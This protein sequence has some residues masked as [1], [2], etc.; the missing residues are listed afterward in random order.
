LV[1]L[2]KG[3]VLR[4]DEITEQPLEKCLM[5]LAYEADKSQ[6]E[7]LMHDEAMKKMG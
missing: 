4:I 2:A 3:D 6:L 1:Q 5:L 7:G